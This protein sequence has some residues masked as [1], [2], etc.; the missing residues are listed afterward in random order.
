MFGGA[1]L[2]DAPDALLAANI[3]DGERLAA[4]A[5]HVG[6]KAVRRPH[7]AKVG[8]LQRR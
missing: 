8:T 3:E 4:E 7:V 1:P 2:P 5:D 6:C